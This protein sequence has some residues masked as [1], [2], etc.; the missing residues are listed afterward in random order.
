MR[1]NQEST[2]RSIETPK[3]ISHR[4]MRMEDLNSF[5]LMVLPLTSGSQLLPF[6]L[7]VLSVSQPRG[8]SVPSTSA[9]DVES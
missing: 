6:C 1:I 2:L 8:Q 9:Q 4:E 3:M 5:I 7:V